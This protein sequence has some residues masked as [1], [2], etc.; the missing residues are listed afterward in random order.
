[1]LLHNADLHAASVQRIKI[2]SVV[3]TEA[4]KSTVGVRTI[5]AARKK[6]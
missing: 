2:V 1:M 6:V 5:T 4:V 3:R